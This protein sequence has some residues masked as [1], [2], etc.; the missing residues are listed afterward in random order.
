MSTRAQCGAG[1]GPAGLPAA[2]DPRGRVDLLL[3]GCAELVTRKVESLI[4]ER[5]GRP[6]SLWD[7]ADGVEGLVSA[8]CEGAGLTGYT[9]TPQTVM[10]AA[11]VGAR[12]FAARKAV[13]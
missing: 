4:G 6:I 1:T 8:F 3:I 13:R 12:R 10:R 9:L 11:G 2:G 7:G 5:V